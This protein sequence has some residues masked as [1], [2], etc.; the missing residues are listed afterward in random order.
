MGALFNH[1]TL[2]ANIWDDYSTPISSV[3]PYHHRKTM[4]ITATVA[5][6]VAA[7]TSLLLVEPKWLVDLRVDAKYEQV[8]YNIDITRHLVFATLRKGDAPAIGEA[9][10]VTNHPAF[11]CPRY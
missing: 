2:L 3:S 7:P 10:Y 4:S 6:S 1:M 8:V 5:S 11:T 9:V